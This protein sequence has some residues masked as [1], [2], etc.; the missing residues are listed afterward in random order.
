MSDTTTR[1]GDRIVDRLDQHAEDNERTRRDH[2]IRYRDVDE[3]DSRRSGYRLR[4][5]CYVVRG[6]IYENA[7]DVVSDLEADDET[8]FSEFA[9]YA[10]DLAYEYRRHSELSNDPDARSRVL[11]A[12]RVA[13]WQDVARIIRE[14]V[15]R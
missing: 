2:L 15:S 3:D 11:A 1:P 4:L 9:A 14:E 13:A 6:G 8:K 5:D 10:E 12:E 7:A